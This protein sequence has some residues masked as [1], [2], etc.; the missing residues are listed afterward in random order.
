MTGLQFEHAGGDQLPLLIV[1][2]F[3]LH[4]GIGLAGDVAFTVDQFISVDGQLAVSDDR[5]ELVIQGLV[6]RQQQLT[7]TADQALMVVEAGAVAVQRGAGDHAFE[8]VQCRSDAQRQ[9]LLAEQFAVAVVQFMRSNREGLLTGNFPALV[10]Y[11]VEVFQQQRAGCI[12]QTALVVQLAVVQ[13][14]RQV[15]LAEQFTALLIKPAE[16]NIQRLLTGDAASSVIDLAGLKR[17]CRTAGEFAAN[18][19]VERAGLDPAT[20]LAVNHTFATVIQT[21]AVDG[22]R[23]VGIDRTG[24]IEQRASAGQLQIA[25]TA[26]TAVAVVDACGIDGQRAVAVD[27]AK[28]IA[29]RIIKGNHQTVEAAERAAAVIERGAGDCRRAFGRGDQALA[30][31]DQFADVQP[32]IAAGKNLAAVAVVQTQSSDVHQQAAGDFAAAV[33][34]VIHR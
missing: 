33:V 19:V 4:A 28:R 12:D 25:A 13:I 22:Q 32:E 6:D 21:A 30:L 5:T 31:V 1:D 29:Q 11:A 16:R 14:E 10:V 3:G 34:D 17:Q 8:V 7:A 20:A 23:A 15:G 27:H 26:E 9:A 2:G 18:A 24:L